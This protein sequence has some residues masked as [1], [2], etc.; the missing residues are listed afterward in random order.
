VANGAVQDARVEA[1]LLQD[2]EH[3]AAEEHIAVRREHILARRTPDADVLRQE[4][5]IFESRIER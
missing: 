4:L 1:P 2:V 5:E 3:D